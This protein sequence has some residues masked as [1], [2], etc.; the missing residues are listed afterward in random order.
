VT[1]LAEVPGD[2]RV[3]VDATAIRLGGGLSYVTRQLRGVE[4]VAPDLDVRVVSAPWND[5]ALKAALSLPVEPSG[6]RSSRGRLVY[7][8]VGLV[9]RVGADAVL[10]CPGNLAP[11]LP[12]RR[13]ATVVT[14][15]NPNLFG[16]GRDLP[17]NKAWYRRL[18]VYG[19]RRSVQV[20]TRVVAVSEAMMAQVRADVPDLGDRGV[21][22]QSGRP[23]WV[24]E[25]VRPDGLAVAGLDY[26]LSL[27]ND[28]PHKR[29]DDLVLAW[30][31]A[32]ADDPDAPALV[33]VGGLAEARREQQRA[34]V[35]ASLRDRLVYTG[36]VAG[37]AELRWLVAHALAMVATSALEAHPHTPAE[38]GAL[39][40]PLVL[41]DIPPHRETAT[42][43]PYAYVPVGDVPA[44]A[45]ALQGVVAD[46][47]RTPWE[48]PI[49]WDD[50]ARQLIGVWASAAP[51][52]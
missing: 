6:V 14:I 8:Q 2:L 48:W 30:V 31:D 47:D 1:E 5:A 46:G 35:P 18:R 42:D 19:A 40:C 17:H 44:L 27:A 21:V 29:L 25:E 9:R 3:V 28:A 15:Q 23:E 36:Q 11:I 41:S 16:V 38:A 50:H 51:T 4:R 10:H 43:H 20:S 34:L 39:G 26:L 12:G 49:S 45:V 22:V 7:E 24:D 52:R 33:F 13:P 32:F 37:P